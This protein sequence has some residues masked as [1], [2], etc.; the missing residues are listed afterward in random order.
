MPGKRLIRKYPEITLIIDSGESEANEFQTSLGSIRIF[1]EGIAITMAVAKNANKYSKAEKGVLRYAE[2]KRLITVLGLA[3]L[4][5]L[6]SKRISSK[7]NVKTN[8]AKE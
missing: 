1:T 7:T 5:S 6:K 3:V 4:N 8:A 2:T